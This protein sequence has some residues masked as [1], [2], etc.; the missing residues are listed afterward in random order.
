MA[1]DFY[2]KILDN[3][4]KWVE[5]KLAIDKDFFKDLAKGQ[6]PPLLWIGCSDSRVPANEIIGAA[7]GEVFVHR[8]IAN[9]VIHSDM[10]MLSVLDYAVNALKIQ[11]II[12]C[13]HY[14]C[15]GVKAAMGNDS[16]GII[17]NWI[18]HIKD[19]YRFHHTYLDSII[20]ENERFNKFVEINVK[21]QVYDLAKTSIVQSAW[22]N[23]QEVSIHGWV[24]GLN[25]GYVTDLNVNIDSN[26]KLDEV[27]QLKF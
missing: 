8:N 13:G 11:H 14:G 26:E 5:E 27:Y 4:K 25:S 12:V 1:S 23:G 16:I 2:R 20:D 21:E 7:P 19:I 18:R 6:T 24:Y 10:N 17:D 9:M 3:N 15:G 22:K